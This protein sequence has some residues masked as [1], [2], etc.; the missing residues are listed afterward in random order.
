MAVEG[1][2]KRHRRLIGHVDPKPADLDRDVSRIAARQHGVIRVDQLSRAGLSPTM[3]KRRLRSGRLHRLY[4]GVYAV[5]HTNLSQEGRWIAAVFACGPKA[6]LSHESAA[7]LWLPYPSSARRLPRDDPRGRQQSP[8][9]RHRP[10]PLER[11]PRQ[12]HNPPPQHPGH[13]PRAHPRRH[14]LGQRADPQPPRTPLL[15]A[16]PRRRPPTP[17]GERQGRSLHRRLP[18][19]RRTPHRRNRRLRVPLLT[20]VV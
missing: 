9:F 3:V 20:S 19:A 14:G 8:P 7:P 5:G 10:A 4:R 11:P 12:G 2:A 18:L 6:V 15:E 17:R 16:G 1:G 13:H